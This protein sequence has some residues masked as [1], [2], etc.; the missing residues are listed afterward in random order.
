MMLQT[1]V[2]HLEQN[3]TVNLNGFAI[4]SNNDVSQDRAVAV[5]IG[6]IATGDQS[7]YANK[8]HAFFNQSN[9]TDT[10][11]GINMVPAAT[12]AA[13]G[14]AIQ[15]KGIAVAG[16]ATCTAAMEGSIR[17]NTTLKAHEGCNGTNWK[18]LY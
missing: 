10:I 18:A 12:S 17:Y 3:N 5:G 16:N 2:L 4:G 13:V 6:G 9:G 8:V 1:E 15:M 14:G 7:V 11:L